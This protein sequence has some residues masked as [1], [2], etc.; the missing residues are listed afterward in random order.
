MRWSLR[1]RISEVAIN[2]E[3]REEILVVRQRT[4]AKLEPAGRARHSDK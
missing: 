3:Q 2:H 4:A 1:R